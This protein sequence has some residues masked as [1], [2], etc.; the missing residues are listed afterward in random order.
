MRRH[1]RFA[2][3][4]ALAAA[5]SFAAPAQIPVQ[6]RFDDSEIVVEGV[7]ER[8]QQIRRFV[9]ALTEAPVRGQIGRFDWAVCPA[10][11]GLPEAQ[12]Q[13]VVERLRQVAEAAGIPLARTGCRANAIVIVTP[14]K[15]AT[16]RW[17]RR[18]HPA[19]FRNGL[20]ERIRI[21]DQDAPATAWQVEGRL[22][23]DGEAVGVHNGAGD[24]STGNYYVVESTRASSRITAASRPHFMASL[25]VIQ[26][27]AL[28]GLTTTQLADYAAMRV[29]ARTQPSRLERS[30][31]P[32][33]LNVIDAPMNSEVPLTLT[34]WDLGF[35]RALYGSAENHYATQQ[36]HEMRRLLRRELDEARREDE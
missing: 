1:F 15:P 18:E 27:D 32:T 14:D 26:L 23:Q 8:Q 4:A 3:F 33:I 28:R 10:A 21:A 17:L 34:Q 29:F 2:L 22:T 30:S 11:A 20:G 24:S 16:L 25:V 31:A 35:L 19:Y 13:A 12:N 6:D 36:R 7:R 9:D 5:G